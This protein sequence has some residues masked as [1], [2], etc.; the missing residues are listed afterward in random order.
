MTPYLRLSAAVLLSLSALS[1]LAQPTQTVV[2]G[3]KSPKADPKHCYQ[4]FAGDSVELYYNDHYQL[5][6][7]ACASIRRNT[8]LSASGTFTGLVCDYRL[9]DGRL[10]NRQ[11]YH[12]G[13][14]NGLYELH[15]PNGRVVVRGQ[16][17]NGLPTGIWQYWYANGQAWQTLMWPDDPQNEHFRILAYWDSTGTQRAKDGNGTWEGI[18]VAGGNRFGG[19]IVDGLAQGTWKSTIIVNGHPY[20][21]ETYERGRF[22]EG[23]DLLG[24]KRQRYPGP[25]VLMP[26]VALPSGAAERFE[27]NQPCAEL[28]AR[29]TESQRVVR[30]PEQAGGLGNYNSRLLKMLRELAENDRGSGPKGRIVLLIDVGKS[31]QL[32]LNETSRDMHYAH[33]VLAM[34]NRLP[35]W[36]PATVDGQPVPGQ[37][38]VEM[39]ISSATVSSY[40][41]P[42]A[43]RPLPVLKAAAR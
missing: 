21:E 8:H 1:S 39:E 27:L 28:L 14:R 41:R 34:L 26:V 16:F 25:A 31:G 43:K 20:C 15:H 32:T 24:K 23:F 17:Q 33:P 37:L 2:L 11:H 3:Q 22:V 9:A 30:P 7:K 35:Q 36:Q 42:A 18:H 29:A 10:L 19:P 6:P 5:T 13:K 4:T 38:T 40:V 12:G